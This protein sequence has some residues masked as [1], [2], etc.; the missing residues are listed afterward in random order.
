MP[1]TKEQKRE[2]YR[3]KRVEERTILSEVD[4]YK[5]LDDAG[6]GQQGEFA[7]WTNLWKIYRGIDPKAD[8]DTKPKK[9]EEEFINPSICEFQGRILTFDEWLELRRLYRQDLW[10]LMQLVGTGRWSEQAHRPLAEFFVKKDNTSLP[11]KYTQSQM[12]AVLFSLDEQHDRLLLYPRGNRKS[13]VNLIDALQWIINFSDIVI[14]IC[15]NTKTLGKRFVKLLRGFFTVQDY[16][17]PT[18]F[19]ILYPDYCIP[20]DKGKKSG[21]VR[22]FWCPLR[23]LRL[24]NPTVSFTSME[25]GT[26]GIRADV[27]KFDDAVDEMNYRNVEQRIVVREK[28]DATSELLIR[29]NGYRDVV[30]TRYTDGLKTDTPEGPEPDLYGTILKRNEINEG[31][32]KFLKAASWTVLSE[33]EDVPIKQLESH[34]VTLL[35]P[36]LPCVCGKTD[37]PEKSMKCQDCKAFLEKSPGSF[38]PLMAKCRDNE[39][40]FR[41][42]Q[43]NEPAGELDD[44]DAY[45]N[46]FTE[47][48]IR[49]AMKEPGWIH[50]IQGPLQRYIFVDTAMTAGR[51]SDYSAFAVAQIEERGEGLDPLIWFIEIRAE[52]Y[53]DQRVAE[54]IAELMQKWNCGAYVEEIPSTGTTFKNEVLRQIHIR[55]CQTLPLRWFTPSQEPKAKETRIRGLQILHEHQLLRFISGPWID[56]TIKQ[57][58]GYAGHKPKGKG[59]RKDDIVD[60]CSYVYKV[61]PFIAGI[62]T[63]EQKKEQEVREEQAKMRRQYEHIHGFSTVPSVNY[64]SLTPEPPPRNPIGDALSPLRS[65]A[66]EDQLSFPRRRMD[67]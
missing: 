46:T 52:R 32:L 58:V 10:E 67:S 2:Y 51:K 36:N 9:T 41:C 5:E 18:Q 56:L 48:N 62:S 22:E 12:S 30:G 49:K 26:A 3:N 59:G 54:I 55:N 19:Q 34:M 61:L 27:I 64:S 8:L 25:S 7:S 50:T 38:L 37:N 1:F 29:P 28:Y 45:V 44:Q 57:F 31:N 60:A 43:L 42:Q 14:L 23:R 15:T 21:D 13:T 20:E 11:Q 65:V 53:T 63:E 24:P 47:D 35:F 17:N 33:F 39:T 66:R 4:K 16:K 6:E 40:S